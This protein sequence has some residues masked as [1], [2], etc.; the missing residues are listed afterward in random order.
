MKE[1]DPDHY[2]VLQNLLTKKGARTMTY[3]PKNHRAYL[4]TASFGETP[5]AT[6]EQ[7]S[8]KAPVIKDSFEVIVAA[9][10]Y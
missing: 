8:P 3:D 9:P 2:S 10:K 1:E 4:V 5:H 7:P 6:K